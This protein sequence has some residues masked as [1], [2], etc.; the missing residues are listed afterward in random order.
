MT[1]VELMVGATL[2]SVVGISIVSAGADFSS[3]LNEQM[4]MEN[5]Y[6]RSNLVRARLLGDADSSS[7][8]ECNGTNNI[9]FTLGDDEATLVE[10]FVEDQKLVRWSNPPN[11]ETPVVEAVASFQCNDL[12]TNGVYV[13]LSLGNAQ[14]PYHLHFRV[15]DSG[16]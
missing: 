13:A 15:S 4:E 10:Y 7:A 16:S 5:T 1:L 6:T 8:V 14:H 11:K 2:F 12:D 3:T 9:G